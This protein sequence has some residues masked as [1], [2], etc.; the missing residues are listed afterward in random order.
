MAPLGPTVAPPLVQMASNKLFELRKRIFDLQIIST[1]HQN[2]EN[3]GNDNERFM[4]NNGNFD[5]AKMHLLFNGVF[6]HI[7]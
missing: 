1:C 2:Y 6:S 7:V 3:R 5:I 4:F